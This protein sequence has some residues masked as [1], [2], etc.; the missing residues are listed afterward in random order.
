VEKRVRLCSLEIHTL[1]QEVTSDYYIPRRS[2][3]ED[4]LLRGRRA[5]F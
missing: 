2:L 5:R 3:Q 1:A 4:T